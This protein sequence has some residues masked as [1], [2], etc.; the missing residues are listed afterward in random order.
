RF[1]GGPSADG[2]DSVILAGCSGLGG[3]TRRRGT[4]VPGIDSGVAGGQRKRERRN[5]DPERNSGC[6]ARG[7]QGSKRSV[8]QHAPDHNGQR[9]G[10]PDRT[11][12]WS[13]G[14]EICTMWSLTTHS[15]LAMRRDQTV[16]FRPVEILLPETRNAGER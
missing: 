15:V 9:S 4:R 8:V 10:R 5:C 13:R 2:V 12:I 6:S 1:G 7:D 3:F 11:L 14:T 16:I